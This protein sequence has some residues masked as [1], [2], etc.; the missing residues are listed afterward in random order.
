M[1]VGAVGTDSLT[2]PFSVT[3]TLPGPGVGPG[4]GTG[5]DT[6]ADTGVGAMMS[7]SW[8]AHAA[9]VEHAIARTNRRAVS[10][11]FLLAVQLDR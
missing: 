3:V 2:R 1:P 6:D 5:V 7:A 11:P 8:L 4:G 9:T 10:R